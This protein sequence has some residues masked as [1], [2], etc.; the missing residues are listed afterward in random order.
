[1]ELFSFIFAYSAI[2]LFLC[3]HGVLAAHGIDATGVP[4]SVFVGDDECNSGSEDGCA[5]NA[6]QRRVKQITAKQPNANAAP[7]S[8]AVGDSNRDPMNSSPIWHYALNC[9]NS[10]GRK[11][12]FCEGY[13][14]P[15]NACCRHGAHHDP[16]ECSFPAFWPVLSFHTCVQVH[17]PSPTTPAPEPELPPPATSCEDQDPSCPGWAAQG[18]CTANT[19]YMS[20]RCGL[21]CGNCQQPADPTSAPPPAAAPPAASCVD[22]S[23]YCSTWATDGQC[24]SNPGYMLRHCKLACEACVSG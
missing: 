12:G 1:M 21:S 11:S 14:G 4:P 2:L 20:A 7:D 6:L 22:E 8:T 24:K 13:C 17:A 15:G 16:E 19:V 9:W 5:V 18:Q 10:C 3:V 23:T